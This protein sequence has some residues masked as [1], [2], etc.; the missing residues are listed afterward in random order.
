MEYESLNCDTDLSVSSLQF[1]MEEVGYENP[2]L[3]VHPFLFFRAKQVVAAAKVEIAVK[4]F[5]LFAHFGEWV[6]AWKD[7][8]IGSKGC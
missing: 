1:A 3:Y 8:K 2:I 7:K 6:L 4:I 5:P